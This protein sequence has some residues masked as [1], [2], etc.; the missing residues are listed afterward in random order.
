MT[1]DQIPPG[2]SI[3][4]EQIFRLVR[5]GRQDAEIAVRMGL[6]T[7]DVRQTVA[8]LVSKCGVRSRDGLM[9]WEPGHV[10]SSSGWRSR[11]ADRLA[12]NAASLLFLAVIVA[13]LIIG[14]WWLF[15]GDSG[16]PVDLRDSVRTAV[17]ET[18]STQSPR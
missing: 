6:G 9:A 7:E 14:S 13:A 12:P 2:L 3:R 16:G 4:E 18:P 5:E 10:P 17:S 8:V 15:R 1:L 11:A